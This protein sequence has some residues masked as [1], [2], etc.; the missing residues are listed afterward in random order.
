MPP[1]LS[2]SPTQQAS[3]GGY[4]V[5]KPNAFILHVVVSVTQDLQNVPPVSTYL[6][7]ILQI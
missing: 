3:L 5:G 1:L 7:T 2:S 4:P 6:F